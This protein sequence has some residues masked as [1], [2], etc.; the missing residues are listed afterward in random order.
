MQEAERFIEANRGEAIG[1]LAKSI[2]LPED[3][4]SRALDRHSLHLNLDA[5]A[6]ESIHETAEF[7]K[8]QGII[9]ALPGF[10]PAGPLAGGSSK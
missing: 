6:L 4:I 3:V 2:G 10:H 5:S 7:L 1:L 9:D 8:T